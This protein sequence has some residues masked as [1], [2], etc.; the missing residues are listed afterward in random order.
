MAIP[1]DNDNDESRVVPMYDHPCDLSNLVKV[2]YD[3]V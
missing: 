2:L 3:G 1:A